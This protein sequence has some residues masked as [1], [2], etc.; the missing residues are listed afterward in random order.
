MLYSGKMLGG[1]CVACVYQFPNLYSIKKPSNTK[2]CL[3]MG[4]GYVKI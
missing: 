4:I 2:K 3:G 1:V